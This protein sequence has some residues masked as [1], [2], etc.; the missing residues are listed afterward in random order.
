MNAK[1]GFVIIIVIAFLAILIL[2]ASIIVNLGCGEILQV[3][4]KNDMASAYYVAVSGAEFM[5]A[6]LKS[7]EGQ[8]VNWPQSISGTVQTRATGGLTIGTFSANA[9]TVAQEVLG[10]TS[11]G[12]VNGHKARITVK[13]GFGSTYTNG[14]PIGSIGAMELYGTRWWALRSWVRAEG[15]LESNSTITTNSYVQVS[16]EIL[17]NQSFVPPHFWWRYNAATGSWT[18]KTIYDTN[19]D[20]QYLTD[21]NGDGSVTVEDAGGDEARIATFNADNTYSSDSVINDKDAF[22]TYYTAEL[23]TAENLNIGPGQVNY[24][25]G[26]QTFGPGDVP[27]GTT[28]IFVNGDANI[29]FND[30]NWAG[31]A[32]DH[33]IVSINDIT[34][35]QPT[36][37]SDDRMTLVAFGNVNTGGVIAFGGVRGNIVI[38]A[39]EDFNAYYGGRTNGTI[40]AKDNVYVDTVLPIPGLLNRDLNRGTGDWADPASWPLGLPRGYLNASLSFSMKNETT[41][42]PAGYVPRWQR[43]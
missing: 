2:I 31:G 4:L 43:Y 32:R 30:Q 13:Y 16:G 22:Y 24:Y 18:E 5:Y 12:T 27:Q 10:I 23:N 17:Q 36:N 40:F 28:I 33:T 25:S 39:N 26:T 37:G 20:G 35:V 1:K 34:I 6:N 7:R 42:P 19:G 41:S 15:P 3:R 38:Y 29:L 11:E 9:N 14:V 21:V 8:I